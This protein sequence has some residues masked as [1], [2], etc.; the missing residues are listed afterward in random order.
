MSRQFDESIQGKFDYH[1]EWYSPVEKIN[2]VDDLAEAIRMRELLVQCENEYEPDS[3]HPCFWMLKQQ[4]DVIK[5]YMDSIGDFDKTVML[6]NISTLLKEHGMKMGELEQILGISTGYISRIAKPGSDKKLSIDVAWKIARLF[7]RS[8]YEL[9]EV[10]YSELTPTEKYLVSFIE[11]LCSDTVA[12]RLEWNRE[13]ADSLNRAEMDING[14]PNHPLLSYETFYEEGET[15]YPDQV[16]R[17][18]LVSRTFDCHTSFN[19][20]CYNLKM[21]NGTYLYIV[22]ICK[23]VH[24]I[25]DKDAY[26]KEIWMYKPQV[27]AH[28]LCS[29][30]DSSVLSNLVERLYAIVC[31]RM[32]HPQIKHELQDVIDAFM[33]DDISDDLDSFPF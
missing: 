13:S 20:D 25:G 7:N 27:G 29:N 23:S 3:G 14:N 5:E 26:A 17:V 28:F 22:N 32:Q 9:L 18:V 12:D 1:D 15:E 6:S 16:S 4:E 30:R 21:K 33:K 11:K 31:D 19:G 2:N 8:L 24:K 10:N